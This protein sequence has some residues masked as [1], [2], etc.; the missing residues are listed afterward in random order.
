MATSPGFSRLRH[1]GDSLGLGSCEELHWCFL[2]PRCWTMT[3]QR[4]LLL[5]CLQPVDQAVCLLLSTCSGFVATVRVPRDS[6]HRELSVAA[7][8]SQGYVYCSC[9][10]LLAKAERGGRCVASER[11]LEICC[12]ISSC[13]ERRSYLIERSV[14][15]A[16]PVYR[17][18]YRLL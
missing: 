1:I 16:V 10:L 3:I 7:V 18:L 15:L 8:H 14:V 12:H 17:L 5:P 4:L 6:A 9:A 11:H 13:V 2:F